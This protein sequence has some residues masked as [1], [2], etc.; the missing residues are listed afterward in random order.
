MVRK[1]NSCILLIIV[2]CL[3]S[4]EMCVVAGSYSLED[5]ID[6]SV[7][8]CKTCPTNAKEC[9]GDR[10][11][12]KRGYWRISSLS[13][14]IMTCPLGPE[15][16]S[17][18]WE[19]GQALCAEGYEG[20]L[21]AVC[22]NGFHLSSSSNTCEL[23][24]NSAWKDPLLMC[25]LIG[26]VCLLT[27]GAC[28]LY[29]FSKAQ[30]TNDP[31]VILLQ[32]LI[33]CR[34]IDGT[35]TEQ[36]RD[37]IIRAKTHLQSRLKIYMIAFQI[38]SAMPFVLEFQFPTVTSNILSVFGIL[39]L[40]LSHS[41]LTGCSNGDWDYIDHLLIDTLFPIALLAIL[42]MAYC[43]HMLY[44]WYS[45]DDCD[46]KIGGIR[47]RYLM[48]AV[49]F[50][51]VTLPAI[52]TSIFRTFPCQNVDP[53]NTV[54]GDNWYM[55]SDYSISCSSSRYYFGAT[56][57]TAMLLVYPVMIPFTYYLL[58]RHYRDVIFTRHVDLQSQANV[59]ERENILR[60]LRILFD[61]YTPGRWYFEIVETCFRVFL[62]GVLVL[63]KPGSSVQIIT[64]AVF[65]LLFIKLYNNS[66]SFEEKY[67]GSLKEVS[68]WQV[69]AVLFVALMI[70]TS[71][72]ETSS[73]AA[74]ALL[75]IALFWNVIY[76]II[77]LISGIIAAVFWSQ[78]THTT[79]ADRAIS[80][81][82]LQIRIDETKCLLLELESQLKESRKI[83]EHRGSDV[84]EEGVVMS[85][86]SSH[87]KD[88]EK[89]NVTASVLKGQDS[90][91]EGGC[92]DAEGSDNDEGM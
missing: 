10:I 51:Y 57:A 76:E 28:L 5:N 27:V 42:A 54:D 33:Q 19:T 17:G 69:F 23:C 13:S 8:D 87:S 37:L 49:G 82:D 60:P 14:T 29:R 11:N 89:G 64:G 32:W 61:I 73:P 38:I 88:V 46:K 2:L 81:S 20:M 4:D 75:I 48:I 86:L 63:I 26:G 85:P 77:R 71:V 72:I 53:D 58:L 43:L 44:I 47:S 84:V 79:G 22:S 66:K 40:S 50:T 74:V 6:L 92:N 31:I 67:I 68:M 78:D 9:H 55:R 18:G 21:C 3:G 91:R 34:V 30:D 65:T 24:R 35:A 12:L 25:V 16:C 56:Y 52:S 59:E 7:T 83:H 1:N 45:V 36:Y 15:S 41:S 80:L 90:V 70:R 39:N 62:T